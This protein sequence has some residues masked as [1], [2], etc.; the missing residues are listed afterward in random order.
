MKEMLLHPNE[1]QLIL[2]IRHKVRYGNIK[3][4]TKDGLPMGMEERVRYRLLS[5]DNRPFDDE[6]EDYIM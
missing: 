2:L 3:I 4:V 6:Q 5:V 1:V